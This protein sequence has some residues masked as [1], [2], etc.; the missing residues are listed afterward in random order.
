M[1]CT[2]CHCKK[3]C[4]DSTSTANCCTN[5]YSKEIKKCHE[6]DNTQIPIRVEIVPEVIIRSTKSKSK[7]KCYECYKK[8]IR[9]C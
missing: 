2:C 8:W 9:E 4:C 7:C 5:C 1:C 6:I 3:S